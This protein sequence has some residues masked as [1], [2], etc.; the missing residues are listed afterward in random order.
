[1]PGALYV[2]FQK[3]PYG[4]S[5]QTINIMFSVYSIPNMVLPLIGGIFLDIIGIRIALIIFNTLFLLGTLIFA[6]GVD[7]ESIIVILIG[8]FV[9]GLGGQCVMVA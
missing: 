1:M 7:A 8:R 9:M 2:Y 5:P 4:Y 6:F 3:E